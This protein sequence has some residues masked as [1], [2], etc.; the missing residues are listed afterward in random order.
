MNPDTN[1]LLKAASAEVREVDFAERAWAGARRRRSRRQAIAG[2][3]AAAPVVLSDGLPA[4]GA[5][6]GILA[7]P[8][9]NPTAPRLLVMGESPPHQEVCCQVAG[10]LDQNTP[11]Y[12][13]V[14]TEGVW[15]LAW[16]TDTGEVG[17][18]F[19]RKANPAAAPPVLSWG[20]SFG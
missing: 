18:A 11:L 3:A 8:L 7:V 13:N 20:L 5:Y 15:L 10:C 9:A 4:D 1:E 2:V 19:L 17:R 12:T 16:H 14:T 6:Q